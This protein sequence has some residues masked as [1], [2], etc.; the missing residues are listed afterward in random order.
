MGRRPDGDW[1]IQISLHHGTTA[2]C[3]S[4]TANPRWILTQPVE[5]KARMMRG[6]LWLR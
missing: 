2:T 1:P 6:F 4:L 5:P 3:L